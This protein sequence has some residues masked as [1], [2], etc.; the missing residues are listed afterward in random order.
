MILT[1]LSYIKM[2]LDYFRDSYKNVTIIINDFILLTL[3][4]N[5]NI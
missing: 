3:N 1:L 5:N 4:L 2:R